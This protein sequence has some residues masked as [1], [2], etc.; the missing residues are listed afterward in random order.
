MSA[1][2]PCEAARGYLA[3]N[4]QPVPLPLRRKK[5]NGMGWQRR[6][7]TPDELPALF[8]KASMNIGI[9]LGEL[10]GWLVDIDLD[11]PE[12]RRLAPHFL[13]STATFGRP[14]NPRSHYFYYSPGTVTQQ[15][16]DPRPKDL[17]GMVI[18]RRS[19]G[20]QTVFPPSL[21]PSGEPISWSLESATGVSCE[22]NTE[23]GQPTYWPYCE[24]VTGPVHHIDQAELARL[25]NRLGAAA[26]SARCWPARGTRNLAAGALGGLLARAGWPSERAAHFVRLVA[27]TAGDE[28][29]E[30]RAKFAATS[31]DNF[32][33]GREVTGLPRLREYFG[34]A[35]AQQ[36][37][38]SLEPPRMAEAR[39]TNDREK[40][41]KPSFA[42]TLIAHTEAQGAILFHTSDR[43]A[44]AS[45]PTSTG[46]VAIPLR[47]TEMSSWLHKE[48]FSLNRTLSSTVLSEVL[49][50]LEGRALHERQR[51]EVHQRVA[52]SEERITLDL[53]TGKVAVVQAGDWS[54]ETTW[55][56]HFRRPNTSLALVEPSKSGSLDALRPLLNIGDDASWRLAAVWLLSTLF[57]SFPCPILVLGGEQG[58]AKTSTATS[59]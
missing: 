16:R 48:A 17:G 18:E 9:L 15:Y 57:P 28:E 24:C 33:A 7:S 38:R 4:W 52:A 46:R 19:T 21:H 35:V 12:A 36:L 55:D 44:F 1:P 53:G 23:E 22:C 45:L 49:G 43:V 54:L 47:S 51:G 2:H 3:R 14:G 27:Q 30:S 20:A 58:T 59:P 50:G 25:C 34:E 11:C 37:A 26:L 40:K 42:A 39:L 6:Q 8:P 13:P 29:Y 32:K 10:S 5:P 56:M 41:D 31:V